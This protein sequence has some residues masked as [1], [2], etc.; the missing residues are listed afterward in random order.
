MNDDELDQRLAAASDRLAGL[1]SALQDGGPW[2]LAARFDHSPEATWGPREI[3]AH[4]AEMLPFWLGEAERILDAADESTPFG[5]VAT[6]EVRLA[7]IE[8]DRALPLRELLASV[9]LGIER[10]RRRWATLDEASRGRSATH[11][12]LGRLSVADV[13]TRFVAGHLEGHLDQLADAVR[14]DS[15]AG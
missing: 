9:D 14:G 12:T 1:R 8:R 11:V 3:L 15:A 7:I 10:W 13:G 2:A 6:D 4:L 5:R